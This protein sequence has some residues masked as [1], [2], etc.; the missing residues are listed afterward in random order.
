MA[1]A[2]A[3]PETKADG[4]VAE[5]KEKIC[6]VEREEFLKHAQPIKVTVNGV[7]LIAVPREFASRAYGWAVNHRVDVLVN[8]KKATMMTT[9]NFPLVYSKYN[10]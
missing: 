3:T 7:D 2:K 9:L 8:G 1:K 6:P 5:T 10:K 4:A